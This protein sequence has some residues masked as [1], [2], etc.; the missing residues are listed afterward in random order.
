MLHAA[1]SVTNP[2]KVAFLSFFPWVGGNLLKEV[3]WSLERGGLWVLLRC[4][5][6]VDLEYV[7]IIKIVQRV[8]VFSGQF[9]NNCDRTLSPSSTRR[10]KRQNHGGMKKM[11]WDLN[12]PPVDSQVLLPLDNFG[13]YGEVRTKFT[14]SV[15]VIWTSVVAMDEWLGSDILSP[16]GLWIWKRKKSW[17]TRVYI[18]FFFW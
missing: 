8:I 1:K 4:L 10:L 13:S 3:R 12:K 15:R 16:H 18:S 2:W 14:W 11:Q 7:P 17:E 9:S 6:N 5:A